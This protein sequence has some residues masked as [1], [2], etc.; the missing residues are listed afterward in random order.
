MATRPRFAERRRARRGSLERPINGRMY[1]GTWLLVGIPLLIAAFSVSR[2][3]PLRPPA[4]PPAFEAANA[5]ADAQEFARDFPDRSPEGANAEGAANWVADRLDGLGLQTQKDRFHVEIPGRGGADLQNVIARRPGQSS[6]AIVVMA[7]RDNSGTG[8]GANDNASG[9]AALLEL[10]R[11]YATPAAPPLPPRPNHTIVFLS[12]D[13]GALRSPRSGSFLAQHPLARP[14]RGRRQPGRHRRQQPAA[15]RDRRR[16]IAVALGRIRA[17]G[18][19]P[20]SWSRA[21]ASPGESPRSD[22]WSTWRSRSAST[23]TRRS[24]AAARRR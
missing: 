3:Q 2:P 17:H 24:S 10:A 11:A 22:S 8:P 19:R 6:D 18:C 16:A 9:T 20:G 5:T 12:T 21:G 15:D 4:L 7:H 23:S 13:G 1:R 14:R